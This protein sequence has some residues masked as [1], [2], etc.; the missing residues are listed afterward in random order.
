MVLREGLGVGKLLPSLI[1]DRSSRKGAY[2]CFGL[3]DCCLH[4][5]NNNDLYNLFDEVS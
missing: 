4:V 2:V 1:V 3:L 5:L